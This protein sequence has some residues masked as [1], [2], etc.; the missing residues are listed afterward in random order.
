MKAGSKAVF[1][2][3]ATLVFGSF[4]VPLSLCHHVVSVIWTTAAGQTDHMQGLDCLM[5]T[6]CPVLIIFSRQQSSLQHQ[7]L[8]ARQCISTTLN[9]NVFG[10]NYLCTVIICR[11]NFKPIKEQKEKMMCKPFTFLL[12]FKHEE[13]RLI[14]ESKAHI[15]VWLLWFLFLLFLFFFHWKR[16]R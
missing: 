2:G 15:F 14:K 8:K 10:S 11:I 12:L 4:L 13:G 7:D 1:G 3:V 6:G 5:M 9:G 16:D